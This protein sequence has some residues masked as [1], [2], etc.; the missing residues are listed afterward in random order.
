MYIYI[1]IM[2]NLGV[3]GVGLRESTKP[4]N[5]SAEI[6]TLLTSYKE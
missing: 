3:P 1:I 6:L 2:Y 5:L 4:G